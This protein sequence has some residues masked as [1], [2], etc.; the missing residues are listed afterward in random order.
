MLL[1]DGPMT[2]TNLIKGIA[3]S[4][5]T[6]LLCMT[7]KDAGNKLHVCERGK[8]VRKQGQT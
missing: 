5:K 3:F 6:P 1:I 8:R 4:A 2:K 7:S